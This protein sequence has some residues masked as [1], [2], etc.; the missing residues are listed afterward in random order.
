MSMS[1]SPL[2]P[3]LALARIVLQFGRVQR[4]THDDL[5]GHETDTTHTVMLSLLA[6]SLAPLD[7]VPLDMERVLRFALVHDLVEVY[8]GDTNTMRTL[9]PEL[10]TDKDAREWV[11]HQRLWAELGGQPGEDTNRPT[12]WIPG[13]IGRYDMQDEPEARFVRYLDKLLP[14]LTHLLNGG[15]ALRAQG[16]TRAEMGQTHVNH[17]AELKAM[18]PEFTYLHGL[19]DAGYAACEAPGALQLEGE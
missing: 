16:V 8:A 4:A 10:R 6:A 11:A 2:A 13:Y 9:S 17:A 3:S 18:Y 12:R 1:S 15:S 5:Y 19:F 14:R 7:A